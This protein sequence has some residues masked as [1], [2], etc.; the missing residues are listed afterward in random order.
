MAYVYVYAPFAGVNW[1]QATYCTGGN[2]P[3][4]VYCC[5]IDIGRPSNTVT[6]IYYCGSSLIKSIKVLPLYQDICGPA[7]WSDGVKVELYCQ[8]YAQGYI[9]AV[10]YGHV[11][12]PIIQPGDPNPQI[13][14]TTFIKIGDT[15]ADNC[16]CNQGRC[17]YCG[18][19]VHMER[20]GGSSNSFYC[21]QPIYAG[22]TWIYRWNAAC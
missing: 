7:P 21:G 12:N 5:P 14:N 10:F 11:N 6:S 15:P 8:L 3:T 18:V 9:G 19:H 17:C 4:E 16:G 13:H 1:G 20:S 22:S 2:H